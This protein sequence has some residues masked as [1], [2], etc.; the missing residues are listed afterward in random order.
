MNRLVNSLSILVFVTGS[1]AATVPA[2]EKGRLRWMSFNDGLAEAAKTN[3]KVLIDVYTDWCGWCKKMDANTYAD[4]RVSEYLLRKYVLVKLNAES[5]QK[6][7]YQGTNYTERELAA[8]FGI[9]GYPATLFLKSNGEAIT[10]YPGYA[11]A[12]MFRNVISFIAEDHYLN[13]KFD[14]YCTSQK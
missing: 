5:P 1:I 6:L 13:K 4:N 8:A 7:T 14:E 3:R 12:A 9:N 10:S 11:D 2:G